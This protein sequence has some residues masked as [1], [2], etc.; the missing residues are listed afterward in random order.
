MSGVC[1]GS[2]KRGMMQLIP[3]RMLYTVHPNIG[4]LM[5]FRLMGVLHKN[6]LD[7]VSLLSNWDYGGRTYT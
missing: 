2:C 6:N 3:T 1:L 5:L 7:L 4:K